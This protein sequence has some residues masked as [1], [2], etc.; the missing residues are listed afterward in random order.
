[1]N[2][3]CTHIAPA[4]VL[5]HSGRMVLLDKIVAADS[6]SLTAHAHISAQHILLPPQA[7][8]LPSYLA[9]E[10]MAQGV[11]AWAGMQQRAKGEAIRLGFLLGTRKLLCRL[12]EIPIGTQLI[13]FIKQSW[14]DDLG[15]G[16]F[17]CELRCAHDLHADF[18]AN[19]VLVSGAMNVYS[20]SRAEDLAKLIKND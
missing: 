18:P 10:I 1:M 6:Q 3:D 2:F 19:S 16:V 12:P 15:M 9:A 5:P 14:Q 20:P 8:A 13:V 11:A 7:L 4:D 17:D